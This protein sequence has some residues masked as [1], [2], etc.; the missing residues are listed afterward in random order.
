MNYISNILYQNSK[1]SVCSFI[2][3]LTAGYPSV[4]LTVKSLYVLDQEGADSIELGIPYS[5]A[6]ADGPLIQEASKVAIN[7]GVNV[8]TIIKILDQIY[9]KIHTPIII[10]TYYN[11]ILVKGVNNF[12]ATISKLGVKGL[13]IPDLPFEEAD[14]IIY[15]CHIYKI[16]LILFISPTSSRNRIINIIDKSPGCLYLV[17][18]TGVT[19]I[20]DSMDE[21]INY[22]S[23][24]IVQNSDKMVMIGFGISNPE[25]VKNIIQSPLNVN[26]IVVGSA[27]TKIFT[28]YCND[29]TINLIDSVR[30][31]CREMKSATF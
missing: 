31:F 26:G 29:T 28:S 11:P 4:D 9:L 10:F 3:F 25:Q 18:S 20:R 17:S 7:N 21:N 16:E 5:D 23:N 14:Y 22:V 24:Q 19:G 13:V 15:V 2:P 30:S 1:K 6:L 27:F 12:I 8:D